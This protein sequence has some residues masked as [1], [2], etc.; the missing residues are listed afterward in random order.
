MIF[1]LNFHKDF[2][3]SMERLVN[4]VE[5]IAGGIITI[6]LAAA[7]YFFLYILFHSVIL[8]SFAS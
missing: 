3:F 5:V 7:D 4:T 2:R 6:A 1:L 8:S